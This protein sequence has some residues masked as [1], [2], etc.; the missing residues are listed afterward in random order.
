MKDASG[1]RYLIPQQGWNGEKMSISKRLDLGR[2]FM[3]VK[4]SIT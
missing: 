3:E 2:K 4:S 1:E